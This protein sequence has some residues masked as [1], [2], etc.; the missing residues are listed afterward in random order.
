MAGNGTE[1]IVVAQAEG[2][3]VTVEGAETH[4]AAAE[5]SA[6]VLIQRPG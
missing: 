4:D 2:E 3:A 6:E 1:I 5:T